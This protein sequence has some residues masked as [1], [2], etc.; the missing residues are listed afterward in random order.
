MPHSNMDATFHFIKVNS[1]VKFAV[2]HSFDQGS[3]IFCSLPLHNSHSY[4][5]L[6]Y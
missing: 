1:Y 4:Y 3:E 5:C 2:D 6:R